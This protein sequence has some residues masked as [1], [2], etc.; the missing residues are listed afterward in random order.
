MKSGLL[1]LTAVLSFGTIAATEVT[2]VAPVP[3]HQGLAAGPFPADRDPG[4]LAFR[5][6][7]T[8]DSKLA[9][10]A[11]GAGTWR[12]VSRMD[13][14]K[15]CADGP[16]R[17]AIVYAVR[18]DIVRHGGKW[19]LDPAVS[20]VARTDVKFFIDGWE[21]RHLDEEL[22]LGTDR[23]RIVLV[24]DFK[25]PEDALCAIPLASTADGA[26]SS[27]V[28]LRQLYA[29]DKPGNTKDTPEE[30]VALD[31]TRS[32]RDVA[33]CAEGA[34][35]WTDRFVYPPD[36]GFPPVAGADAYEVTV[37]DGAGVSRTL[38]VSSPVVPF[39]DFWQ[40][41]AT[42]GVS[43]AWQ[44]KDSV[45]R[46]IGVAGHRTFTKADPFAPDVRKPTV[47]PAAATC[48]ALTE[49]WRTLKLLRGMESGSRSMN[50][51]GTDPSDETSTF[52]DHSPLSKM[53]PKG[54]Q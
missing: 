2:H 27:F 26:P 29:F 39:A 49:S 41:M 52:S 35:G 51:M 45:G 28:E 36:L 43:V 23:H 9:D 14:L 42:G 30:L 10:F 11:D 16:S 48:P 33:V 15:P 7:S 54:L 25:G 3:F 18:T 32:V 24:G 46:P 47:H 31:L 17:L 5:A 13:G 44:A 1:C 21:I 19:R 50:T 12:K 37:K 38:S 20:A 40:S 34:G 53:M 4:N 6:F 8:A 22:T